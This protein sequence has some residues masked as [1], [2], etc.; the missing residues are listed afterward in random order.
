LRRRPGDE[1]LVL[2]CAVD[3]PS[4]RPD[5]VIQEAGHLMLAAA[6]L[7]AAELAAG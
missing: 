5:K 7:I 6:K 4:S 2:S 3:L 1:L